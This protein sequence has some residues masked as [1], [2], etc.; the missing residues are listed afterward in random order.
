MTV[1]IFS[2]F[3][4]LVLG[5]LMNNTVKLWNLTRYKGVHEDLQYSSLAYAL[6]AVSFFVLAGSI[7]MKN[8][9]LFL[10]MPSLLMSFMQSVFL[11]N[12]NFCYPVNVRGMFSA[13]SGRGGHN[14][15]IKYF[16]TDKIDFEYHLS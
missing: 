4:P 10:L 6:Q 15:T 12:L 2:V 3:I 16:I 8:V 14:I 13:L 5:F 9:W 7:F 11:T 1:I